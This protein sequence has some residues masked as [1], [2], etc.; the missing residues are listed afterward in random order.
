MYLQPWVEFKKV[1]SVILCMIQ[2]FYSS[3]TDISNKTT[4]LH[5]IL[6]TTQNNFISKRLLELQ[7]YNVT[8]QSHHS[9]PW[10]FMCSCNGK[11]KVSKWLHRQYIHKYVY[12]EHITYHCHVVFFISIFYL[13]IKMNNCGLCLLDQNTLYHA[14]S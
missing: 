11:V 8:S 12:G 4:Q 14:L 9:N 1:E 7:Y 2:I 13:K 6:N 10:N 3:C 5:C